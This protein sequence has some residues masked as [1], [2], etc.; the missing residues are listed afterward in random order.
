[1]VV[2]S[3]GNLN[4]V[5]I[6]SA[7]G[8]PFLCS[9]TSAS[10]TS[11]G[12]PPSPTTIPAATG[13]P[14]LHSSLPCIRPKRTSLKLCGRLLIYIHRVRVMTLTLVLATVLVSCGGSTSASSTAT[15]GTNGSSATGGTGGIG[16][17][18]GNT[19]TVHV[20]VLAQ[21]GSESPTNLG[22]VTAQ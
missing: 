14:C 5:W 6:D 19:V 8:L 11:F 3:G 13:K 4:L 12:T 2:D 20:A 21:S 22:T 10:G 1:M 16:G 15:G 9:T 18:G 17:T 7:K